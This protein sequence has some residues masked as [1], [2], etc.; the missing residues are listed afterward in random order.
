M[1]ELQG[2]LL[3]CLVTLGVVFGGHVEF[4]LPEQVIRVVPRSECSL[5][6]VLAVVQGETELFPSQVV[7]PSILILSLQV[8]Y[9]EWSGLPVEQQ[10]VLPHI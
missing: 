1:Q 8:G 10:A 2:H 6:G 5:L 9:L 4:F 3:E 7:P